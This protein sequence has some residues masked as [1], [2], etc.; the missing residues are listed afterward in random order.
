[1]NSE[2]K[3]EDLFLQII[4]DE[5]PTE[6]EAYVVG[7]ADIIKA[8]KEGAV[9]TGASLGTGHVGRHK[10][11][12]EAKLI[13]ECVLLISKTYELIRG[14]TRSEKTR[15]DLQKTW[16]ND[17]TAAGLDKAKAERIAAKYGRQLSEALKA[18]S[19]RV[20]K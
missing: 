14:W 13:L 18:H 2:E 16:A 12:A 1:M 5:M 17:L 19:T 6:L 7:K 9:G 8:C 3:F 10:F 20:P 15:D 11:L 4:R